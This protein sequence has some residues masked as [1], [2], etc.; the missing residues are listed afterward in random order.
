MQISIAI[1]QTRPRK[2][3]Y[4]A[5]LGHIGAIF[6]QLNTLEQCPDVL[7][8]PETILTGYFLEGGVREVARSTADVATD[9]QAAYLQTCDTDVPPLDV[10]VGFY[11]RYR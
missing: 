10:V 7:V 8:F 5:N 4:A 9:L 3:D 11:E 6:D 1:A 2:G